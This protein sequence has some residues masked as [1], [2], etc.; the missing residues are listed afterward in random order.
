MTLA[1]FTFPAWV[2]LEWREAFSPS[3][4]HHWPP[5]PDP[6]LP[7]Y[8]NAGLVARKLYYI[9][10][11]RKQLRRGTERATRVLSLA[12]VRLVPMRGW[13][14]YVTSCPACG[15]NAT[16]LLVLRDG[17]PPFCLTCRPYQ[18]ETLVGLL[19]ALNAER[20]LAPLPPRAAL[21]QRTHSQLPQLEQL[22]HKLTVTL[23]LSL[24]ALVAAA[25]SP[26]SRRA[27]FFVPHIVRSPALGWLPRRNARKR[28]DLAQLL[29]AARSL[30]PVNLLAGCLSASELSVYPAGSVLS[31]CGT[32]YA[33]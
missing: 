16:T 20:R 24:P 12:G 8:W 22:S 17:D 4:M 23:L 31:V 21:L 13:K 5:A 29:I 14:R 18:L 26:R 1:P 25:N 27:P 2:P 3:L 30:H 10:E 9:G 19:T 11:I 33:A 15:R 6:T 7:L 28:A 32:G